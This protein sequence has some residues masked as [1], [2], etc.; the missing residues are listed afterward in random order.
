MKY[1]VSAE[2]D[3][4]I[5]HADRTRSES[6]CLGKYDDVCYYGFKPSPGRFHAVISRENHT[7]TE[8]ERRSAVY[9]KLIPDPDVASR[10]DATQHPHPLRS[11]CGHLQPV[12]ARSVPLQGC[13]PARTAN[14]PADIPPPFCYA[15]D[16][17]ISRKFIQ[18]RSP[19]PR[20]Q[21]RRVPV[22]ARSPSR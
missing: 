3:L 4:R 6:G 5:P 21:Q 2:H 14:E 10:R 1:C 13:V 12:H 17:G 22:E 20:D 15:V 11:W 19:L 18:R 16:P 9:R 8:H 7:R